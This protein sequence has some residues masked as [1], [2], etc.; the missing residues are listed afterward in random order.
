[1]LDERVNE[2]IATLDRQIHEYSLTRT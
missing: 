1:L 2:L